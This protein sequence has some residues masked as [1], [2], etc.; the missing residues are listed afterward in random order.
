MCDPIE[1]RMLL[2]LKLPLKIKK[3]QFI[4]LPASAGNRYKLL[5]LILVN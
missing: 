1:L 2:V 3:E 5:Y 4:S